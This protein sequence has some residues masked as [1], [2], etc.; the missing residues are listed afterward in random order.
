MGHTLATGSRE[1]LEDE[2]HANGASA[3]VASMQAALAADAVVDLPFQML[4][5]VWLRQWV[6]GKGDMVCI[7][8]YDVG[9]SP[10]L[11]SSFAASSTLSPRAAKQS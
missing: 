10:P 8:I 2:R 1:G 11:R 7:I 9:S 5:Q 4:V 6:R 3:P